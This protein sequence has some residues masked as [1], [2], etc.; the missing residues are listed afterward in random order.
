MKW[1]RNKNKMP[2]LN[3][4]MESQQQQ[5]KQSID[6]SKPKSV[7]PV[8]ITHMDMN[9][10]INLIEDTRHAETTQRRPTTNDQVRK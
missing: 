10:L 6:I 2:P 8:H 1:K 9:Q 7:P 4:N 3:W 5:Q